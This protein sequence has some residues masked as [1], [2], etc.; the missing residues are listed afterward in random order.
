MTVRELIAALIEEDMG[1]T[2][3]IEVEVNGQ[4][5][6]VDFD[7]LRTIRRYVYLTSNDSITV[8]GEEG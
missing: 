4:A 7:G 3:M 8:E 2:V 1:A 5:H 6:E